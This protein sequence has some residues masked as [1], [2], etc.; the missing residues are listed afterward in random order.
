MLDNAVKHRRTLR[1]ASGVRT[2]LQP[3]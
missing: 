2:P 3:S 1:L